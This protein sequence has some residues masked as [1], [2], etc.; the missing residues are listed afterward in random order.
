M[1]DSCVSGTSSLYCHSGRSIDTRKCKREKGLQLRQRYFITYCH[2]GRSI[3]TRKYKREKGLQ[4]RHRYF[5]TYCHASRSIYTKAS[6]RKCLVALGSQQQGRTAL[7]LLWM[8]WHCQLVHGWMVY[9]ELAPRRQQFHV[10]PAMQ[11]PKSAIS[12]PL[13]RILIIRAIKNKKIKKDT[14]T[15]SESHATCAQWVCSRAENSAI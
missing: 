14:I 11:Q 3:D 2:A 15:H 5:I 6:K 12:T 7:S 13:P 10:A 4:L 9:T 1:F 8:K